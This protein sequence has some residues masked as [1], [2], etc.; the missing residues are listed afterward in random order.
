MSRLL[1]LTLYV[2][3][4]AQGQNSLSVVVHWLNVEQ[5]KISPAGKGVQDKVRHHEIQLLV[6]K[7]RSVE[8]ERGDVQTLQRVSGQCQGRCSVSYAIIVGTYVQYIV[9]KRSIRVGST[10]AF[11]FLLR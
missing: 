5:S 7:N 2:D 8:D 9:H 1:E 10:T 11:Y 3:R 4:G 6:D